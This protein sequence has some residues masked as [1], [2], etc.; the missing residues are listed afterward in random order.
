MGAQPQWIHL[1]HRSGIY[2][3]GDILVKDR[4]IVRAR[5]PRGML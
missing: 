5:I 1:Q 4:K 2:D 3:S